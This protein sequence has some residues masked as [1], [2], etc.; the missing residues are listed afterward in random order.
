MILAHKIK[1]KPNNKQVTYFKKA[2]GIARFA[3]NWGL[4]YN[5]EKYEKDS[6]Y[7]FNEMEIRK[8][9]NAI[10]QEKFPWMYEVTKCAS[11]MAIK[12]NLKNAFSNFFGNKSE[13]PKFHKKGIHESFE[14]TNEKFS[15]K[16]NQ[17]RIPKLGWVKMMESL[18]FNG[19]IMN[20][21]VSTRAGY[22]FISIQVEMK[23]KEIERNDT[24]VVG[25]DLGVAALI[26]LSNGE[27]YSG[28]KATVKYEKKLRRLKQRLAKSKGNKK[29][30]KKSNNF[31]KN[32]AKLS[33]LYYKIFNIRNDRNH[34]LSTMLVKKYKTICVENLNVEKMLSKSKIAKQIS[35]SS[36]YMLRQQ[37]IYKSKLYGSSIVTAER[38]FPSSKLCSTCG[39][40]KET[41]SLNQRVYSCSCGLKIDRDV[42][43][44][45]NLRNYA[46]IHN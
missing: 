29:G 20:A 2:C 7:I 5:K 26:T 25:V 34:N 42:N 40:K 24:E 44:A 36:F 6:N 22:W 33:K 9:L 21:T 13:Y 38:Y 23:D 41:L 30:E 16:G 27:K 8:A 3:Y 39:N 18:R 15:V 4:A 14:L 11:Q 12:R 45:I 31:R 28:A 1:L 43:A 37:L 46:L 19:K 17:V 32:Q 10:K 35:D